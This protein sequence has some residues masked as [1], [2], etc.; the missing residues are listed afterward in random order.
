VIGSGLIGCE[1]ASAGTELGLSTTIVSGE[2]GP[3][4][5]SLGSEASAYFA[6]LQERAGVRGIF[7]SQVARVTRSG[8]KSTITLS[9]GTVI[10]ADVI[11]A[12]TGVRPA[13]RWLEDSGV[14]LQNG[15]VCDE[16][17]RS[18]VEDIYAV[19]DVARWPG[20]PFGE[21]IRLEHWASAADQG[22]AVARYIADESFTAPTNLSPPYFMSH[23]H[24]KRVQAVGHC[25]LADESVQFADPDSSGRVF[26][27]FRKGDRLIGCLAVDRPR[28]MARFNGLIAEGASWQ[29]GLDVAA[30]L[31]PP[32][33]FVDCVS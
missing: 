15:V 17:F 3:F 28:F 31:A 23:L 7:G 5:A 29:A 33:S 24:G 26:F 6:S 22:S 32:A 16:R 18:S 12:G 1:V 2:S 9:D 25:S 13:T 27:L 30:E 4:A 8:S 19:G 20:G 21:Q 10:E 14:T 11:V